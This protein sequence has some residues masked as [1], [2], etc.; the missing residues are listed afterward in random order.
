MTAK[1]DDP[2][3]KAM[4]ETEPTS[5]PVFIG[6]SRAPTEVIDADIATVTGAADK[7]LRVAAKTPYLL[8]LEFGSGHDAAT[9]PRK[10][11]VR[12]GL[13]E[14]RHELP[15][16]SAVV[17][18]RPEA[19]SPQLTGVYRQR[20][21]GDEKPYLVFR[22]TVLRVWQLPVQPLLRGSLAQ[23]PLAVISDVTAPQLPGIIQQMEQRLRGR[24]ERKQVPAIWA[25]AYI[26]AGLRFSPELAADLFQGVVSMKESSTYQAILAEGRREGRE[27]G[28][29][30]EA[31][32][33][34]RFQ[35]EG[36]FGTPDEETAALLE[37]LNDLARLEELLHRV[38]TAQSW[39]ELLGLPAPK[40]A[41]KRRRS[42]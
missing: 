10:L 12:N 13:L 15:V 30:E 41:S 31:K 23:L 1:P 4:V 26:L 11:H 32:K 37:Q 33:V 25:A 38:R 40:P 29:V 28:N 14:D 39:Q 9:L 18:L 27:E 3:L 35:G 17:V 2:T 19:D 16:R 42:Q 20:L 7:V 5:W 8:H 21:A 36:A 34:L 24:R 22:Y 6:Q